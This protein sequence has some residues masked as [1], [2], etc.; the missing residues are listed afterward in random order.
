MS[1]LKYRTAEESVVALEDPLRSDQTDGR[2]FP[3]G[4]DEPKHRFMGGGVDSTIIDGRTNMEV[5]GEQIPGGIVKVSGAKNSATKLMAA[6]L[7]TEERIHLDNFPTELVDTRIKAAFLKDIG[8]FVDA[9][10]RKETIEIQATEIRKD[11][12]SQYN[13]PMRSTYLLAAGQLLRNGTAHIPYPGG[14][15]I[16]NRKYDLHVMVWETMGCKVEEFEDCISISCNG[17]RGAEI[18]F[19][20]PTVGGT[21]NALLC[22]SIAKGTSVIRNAYIS[23]EVNDLIQMLVMMGADIEVYGNSQIRVKGVDS[24]RGTSYRVMPDRIEA[25]TWIIYAVLSKGTVIVE[26]VPFSTMEVP[27]IHLQEAGIDL[28]RNS[29]SVH[30]SPKCLENFVIQPFEVACGT[31]PGVISDMQPF[32][33]LL[34]LGADGRSRIIDYRYPERTAYL[35][36]LEKMCP[37]CLEWSAAGNINTKGPA[38]LKASTVNS[39]D[40]RGSMAVVL[41]ALLARG[42][43]TITNVNMAFRGYNKLAEKLSKLGIK[44]NLTR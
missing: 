15:K 32:Y 3:G 12:L 25:L 2:V 7:L 34:G 36:E 41:A 30:I 16:A 31:H 8:V 42:H 10:S 5:I 37:G 4:H 27:L 39:T 17:L 29:R 20:F 35:S 18:S 6:A 23:P 22:C 24:L 13:Y 38:E 9:D 1:N 21:E 28:F 33:V 26:D 44:Y 43:T 19:P 11:E 40:L 14:C